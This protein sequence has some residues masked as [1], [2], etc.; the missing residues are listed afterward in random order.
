MSEGSSRREATTGSTYIDLG[1]DTAEGYSISSRSRQLA[2]QMLG[3]LSLEDR[4]RQRC[5]IA[6][7]DF[8]MADIMRFNGEAINAGLE[9]LE[10][11]APIFADI[12]MVQTGVQKKGHGSS[13]DCLLDHGDE[14]SR[15]SGITRTS[16]GMLSLGERLNGSIVVIGNA[17][18][19]LLSLCEMH[20]KGIR[21]ALVVGCPVGFVNA[22]ES[23]EKRRKLD[24][25][26]ISTEGTRGGTPVAVA[27]MNEIITIFT[28]RRC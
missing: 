24:L 22:A 9:A 25:P 17:P 21:P 28:E 27:A 13:V 8:S 18:S 14:I 7:G 12:R 2:R 4:I 15:A 16:A 6:V 5:S 26:S 11:K 10:A 3:D 20:G 19:C 1:A 23:K